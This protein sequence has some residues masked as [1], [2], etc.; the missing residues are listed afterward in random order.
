MLF[1]TFYTE[2]PFGLNIPLWEWYAIGIGLGIIIWII[3][4]KFGLE[5]AESLGGGE[6]GW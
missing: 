6:G 1:W 3:M 5:I 4:K 2:T